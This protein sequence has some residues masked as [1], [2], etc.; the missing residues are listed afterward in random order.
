MSTDFVIDALSF[1]RMRESRGLGFGFAAGA[2]WRSSLFP[3]GAGSSPRQAT[4][5]LVARQERRQRSVP[6][7]PGPAGC[8]RG[9]RLT[10]PVAKLACGSDNATG[11][12]PARRLPLGG[13]EGEG[14]L[15]SLERAIATLCFQNHRH[16]RE[17]GNP[18]SSEVARYK[19]IPAFAGMTVA[20]F[21]GGQS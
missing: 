7:R 17:R 10:G 18:A 12:L 20:T 14:R 21:A 5:F 3:L 1:P 16:S 11:L 4:F 9:R 13:T 19:W 2:E 15:R 6:Y 8:P